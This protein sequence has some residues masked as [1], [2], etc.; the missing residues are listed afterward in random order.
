MSTAIT[1]LPECPTWSQEE[2]GRLT[3]SLFSREADIKAAAKKSQ[4]PT[5][6]ATKKKELKQLKGE[7]IAYMKANNTCF[8]RDDAL[9][10]VEIKTA[11]KTLSRDALDASLAEI[12]AGDSAKIESA[13]EIIKVNCGTKTTYNL[14][15]QAKSSAKRKV[16]PKS[17][18]KRPA[19]PSEPAEDGEGEERDD[20]E[21]EEEE[22]A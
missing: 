15:K 2:F 16:A 4:L 20:E 18:T 13:N 17:A 1:E 22:D 7:L 19:S 14:K 10:V 3:N 6:L 5:D 21:E 11:A 8:K 12:F 9:W